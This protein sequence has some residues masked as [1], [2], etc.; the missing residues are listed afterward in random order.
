MFATDTLSPFL[1]PDLRVLIPM[2]QG[3]TKSK[4]V[5]R[6]VA[7]QQEAGIA[8]IDTSSSNWPP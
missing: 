4:D 7:W 3:G 2:A 5:K 6:H 1:R 8:R